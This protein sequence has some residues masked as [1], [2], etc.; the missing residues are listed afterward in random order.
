M[1][2]YINEEF[3]NGLGGN[4]EWRLCN[5]MANK[6]IR[7]NEICLYMTVV[8][9]AFGGHINSKYIDKYIEIYE[10]LHK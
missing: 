10:T 1:F 5:D 3:S 9:Y 7:K 2:K 4:D 6:L 8:H